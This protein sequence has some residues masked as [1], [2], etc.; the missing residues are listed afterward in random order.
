ME[1]SNIKS[2]NSGRVRENAT[3][4][5]Y[6]KNI[7]CRVEEGPQTREA[8]LT[9]FQVQSPFASCASVSWALEGEQ[10][11]SMAHVRLRGPQGAE[12]LQTVRNN[13]AHYSPPPGA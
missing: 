10:F 2:E 9:G 3:R 6:S 8:R 4:S 7:Q 12:R 1:V 13:Q 11:A 5:A